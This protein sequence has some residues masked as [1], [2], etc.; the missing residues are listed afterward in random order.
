M[1]LKKCMLAGVVFATT[2]HCSP[3]WAGP[4]LVLDLQ[5]AGASTTT[6]SG[7]HVINVLPG[8]VVNLQLWGIVKDDAAYSGITL[9][10]SVGDGIVSAAMRFIATENGRTGDF[11]N[12]VKNTAGGFALGSNGTVKNPNYDGV[13]GLDWGGAAPVEGI[14]TSQ[15][16]YM[17]ASST[18]RIGYT[19]GSAVLLGTIQW[20]VNSFNGGGFGGSTL[21]QAVPFI[22]GTTGRA[23]YNFMIGGIIYNS[24]SDPASG[25]TTAV[26]TNQRIKAGPGVFVGVPIPEPASL[27]VLGVGG[28]ALL[29]RRR[30]LCVSDSLFRFAN[31]RQGLRGAFL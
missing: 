13:G 5:V 1:N 16:G 29:A 8:Q 18:T 25:N 17:V 27:A 10:A 11:G 3:A 12:G 14:T 19:N 23:S 26:D 30:V 20:T 21:L 24:A 28:L 4:V 31:E 9:P 2:A 15:T 7:L 6:P 22:N